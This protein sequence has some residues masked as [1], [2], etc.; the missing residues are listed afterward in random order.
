MGLMYVLCKKKDMLL[1]VGD[2]TAPIAMVS[3]FGSESL[4]AGFLRSF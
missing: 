4:G 3:C 1:E 2:S